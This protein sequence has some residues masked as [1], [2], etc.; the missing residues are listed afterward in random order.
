MEE[1]ILK[2]NPELTEATKKNFADTFCILNRQKTIEKISIR[3]ICEKA[4]YNRSTFYQY[5]KDIYD[6]RDF[7]EEIIISHVK[8]NFLVNIKKENFSETFIK[9]F[10][11]IQTDKA[12]YFDVMMNLENRGRFTEK[13]IESVKKIFI[14]NFEIDEE[15]IFSDYIV[16]VYFNT[17]FSVINC[18][19]KNVRNLDVKEISKFISEILTSGVMKNFAKKI[20][21][22]AE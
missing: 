13:L 12:K 14:K 17:V 1:N 11:K 5:F 9:A 18:W 3:E 4:G 2:K 16:E 21:D 20:S 22:N 10:T 7:V 15:K 8:E 19:I 6:L